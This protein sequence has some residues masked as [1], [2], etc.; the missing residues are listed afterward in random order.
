MTLLLASSVTLSPGGRSRPSANLHERE[1]NYY[2]APVEVTS[3]GG[4]VA[5][6]SSTEYD[7]NR[8]LVKNETDPRNQTVTYGYDL[9]EAAHVVL[10][11]TANPR[12][13]TR[14]GHPKACERS[15]R[16]P[17]PCCCASHSNLPVADYCRDYIQDW[18][19]GDTIPEKS[20]QRI[21]GVAD[22]ILKAGMIGP[23]TEGGPAP[24]V[25]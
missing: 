20:A 19:Q 4:G 10:A 21:F 24:Q 18:L 25:G 15:K 12:L 16:K 13:A 1:S 11:H 23:D 17:L 9:A 2:S 7:F 22:R 3:G 6:T 14:S 5:L 8:S